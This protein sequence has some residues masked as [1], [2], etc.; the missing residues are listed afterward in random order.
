[1]KGVHDCLAAAEQ[2]GEVGV[3]T[4]VI[5]LRTLRPL[6][7]DCVL[8]SLAKTNR[9]AV[10]EEGPLTGGWA[11]ELL[12]LLAEHGLHDIDDVWRLTTPEHPIPYSPA[13]EDAFLPGPETIVASVGE[14]LDVEIRTTP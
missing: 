10:V 8:R 4:E 6:D 3:D 14:R 1:M 12:A 13:L 5:D 7:R 2:L 11:G 9:L